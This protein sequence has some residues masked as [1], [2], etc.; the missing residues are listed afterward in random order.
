MTDFFGDNLP[1]STTILGSYN[2]DKGSYNITLNNQTLSFDERVDGW[3]S[4]KSFI[5]ENGFSLNNIYYTYKN[6]DLYS[7]DS[8]ARNTFYDVASPSSV[9]FIFNDFPQS[10]KSFKTLNYEG[11]DSRKYTYGGTTSTAVVNGTINSSTALV[12]DGH[13]T[14]GTVVV[15]DIITGTGISGTVTV[16]T[17]TDQNNLVLSSAQSISDGVTL[18]FT[19][20]YGAG[21]TLE[22]LKKVG[23]S[24]DSIAALPEAETKGWFADSITTDQQT[25]SVRFFKEKEN[26]KFNQILGDN[27]TSSNIDT[28]ELS[29]QG[30]GFPLNISDSGTVTRTLTI[31]PNITLLNFTI[32]GSVTVESTSGVSIGA[33][34]TAVFTITPN[35]GYV[36][37]ASQVTG[38]NSL[39]KIASANESDTGTAGTASNTVEVTFNL[40]DEAIGSNV[41]IQPSISITTL[42][43]IQYTVTGV[44]NTDEI[45]TSTSSLYNFGYSGS[46]DYY[47]NAIV[48][49]LSIDNSPVLHNLTGNSLVSANM[50][51]IG[52]GVPDNALVKTISGT[53]LTDLTIKDG[54]GADLNATIPDDTLLRFGKEII[55]KTFV[56]DSGFEFKSAPT[57]D[58]LQEDES[59]FSDYTSSNN[60]ISTTSTV[61]TDVSNSLTVPLSAA[62]SLIAVGMVVSGSGISSYTTVA[63]ISS[64]TLTL[65]STAVISANT[66]LSF[67]PASVTLK[68]YYVFSSNNPTEDKILLTAKA[69]KTFLDVADEITGMEMSTKPVGA[70]GETRFIR[71][72]GRAGSKFKLKKFTTDT[73]NG[74]KTNSANVTLENTNA[75]ILSGMRVEGSGIS[76][77]MRVSGAPGSP[78]IVAVSPNI[79]VADDV[80][81]TFSEFWNGEKFDGGNLRDDGTLASLVQ[82]I[83][84]TG[85]YSIPVEYSGTSVFRTFNYEV[86]SQQDTALATDFNGA[87]PTSINQTTEV[88]WTISPDVTLNSKVLG[89]V[90][91]AINSNTALVIDTQSGGNIVVGD[92][93]TGVGISGVVTVAAVADQ[94]NLTLSTAQTL[95]DN[96][97]LTFTHANPS[98]TGDQSIT[99]ISLSEPKELSRSG[100]VNFSFTITA[101]DVTNGDTFLSSSRNLT[102]EDFGYA[103]VQ[104]TVGVIGNGSN[105][106]VLFDES[107][108]PFSIQSGSN[109]SL[110]S[111]G[112]LPSG[113][114]ISAKNV[115]GNFGVTL[116]HLSENAILLAANNISLDNVITF[117]APN[118]WIIEYS[119]ISGN[120]ATGSEPNIYTITGVLE[121]IRF[122]TQSLT[123]SIGLA[124]LLSV[125]GAGAAAPAPLN[126]SLVLLGLYD[127]ASSNSG[128]I[129]KIKKF[130]AIG[131]GN[132]GEDGD[133]I[134][135]SGTVLFRG[136]GNTV[137]GTTLSITASSRFT[138]GTAPTITNI[139]FFDDN[140][141]QL[142]GFDNLPSVVN[143]R[144]T[145]NFTATCNGDVV[146]TDTLRV[147][148]KV[149]LS[150]VL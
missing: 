149:V 90:A 104:R 27:T 42:S 1:L 86:E 33:G 63:G 92:V 130:V 132:G 15:G 143:T 41:T 77:G 80:E 45:N 116:S 85:V 91:G 35:T 125:G 67:F 112:S 126:V 147:T 49:G 71:V 121:V 97:I 55:S 117:S 146:S 25:G 50:A 108:Q 47:V 96:R 78:T 5:P 38:S 3:T 131:S 21:T 51:I 46:G 12:I 107:V 28:K 52:S 39:S 56:A 140:D 57:L 24:P 100:L 105:A 142:T 129:V 18:T 65:S 26:F 13:S 23:L 29:V 34:K 17:V 72:F 70:R 118:D 133:T 79:S 87:N 103:T 138:G 37:S 150:N 31:T 68:V 113:T 101:V 134:S 144:V 64:S 43:K 89:S 53:N 48:N 36:I 83:P 106:N 58:V 102:L 60:F 54:T 10:V 66:V 122:G 32:S 128:G 148:I 135:G 120:I 75:A 73:V 99:G 95:T 137:N 2:D 123:S 4:F 30:L 76:P 11:S 20:V 7:H 44:F 82:T 93:V 136:D 8:A 98:A 40:V 74:S 88:T 84:S 94:D 6:G 59:T 119:N 69:E 9:K 81:L 141:T 139:K 14:G 16:T 109:S 61:L 127:A 19:P 111:G 115:G 114:T 124:N 62:N 22:V 110:V 145:F